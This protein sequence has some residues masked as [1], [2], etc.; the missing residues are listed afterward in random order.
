MTLLDDIQ[1]V[2]SQDVDTEALQAV[3]DAFVSLSGRLTPEIELRI[4]RLGEN[5]TQAQINEAVAQIQALLEE[6]LDDFAGYLNTVLP[7][8]EQDA[9]ALG[10]THALLII[11]LVYAF[12][13]ISQEPQSVPDAGDILG[14]MLTVGSPLYNRLQMYGA[15]HAEQIA[16]AL[17]DALASGIGTREG[18]KTI[19]EILRAIELAIANPLADALRLTRTALLYAYRES[20]RLNYLANSDIISGWQWSAELDDRVCMSCVVM[21]GTIHSLEETLNDH[22]NG[23]CAMIPIVGEPIINSDAGIQWFEALS[24]AQ[25]RAMLGKGK[26]EAWQA[27]KFELPDI[28]TVYQDEV[29][30]EMR[31][32]ASLKG[33]ING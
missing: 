31:R 2:T 24:E 28:S 6:E 19:A 23:R 33:L 29:Y 32:E 21:H 15:Y 11:G 4:L 5:P 27:G 13:N 25:Q 18:A 17:K 10:A 7:Q 26:F 3:L 9:F 12:N 8:Y 20:T 30:G 1:Q 16:Q 14:Q 22:H